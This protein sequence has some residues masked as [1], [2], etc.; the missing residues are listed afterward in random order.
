[1]LRIINISLSFSAA[2]WAKGGTKLDIAGLNTP[3][4]AGHGWWGKT[5]QLHQ[6]TP[7][8]SAPPD[9]TGIGV[10]HNLPAAPQAS[11]LSAPLNF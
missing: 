2:C 11:H 6:L 4:T 8:V 10:K 7:V 1:M 9:G 5:L 3:E